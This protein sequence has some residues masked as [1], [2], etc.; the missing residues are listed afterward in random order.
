MQGFVRLKLQLANFV[1]LILVLSVHEMLKF[2]GL[3]FHCVAL[4]VPARNKRS[5]LPPQI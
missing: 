3:F 5:I 1:N 4:K 2:F